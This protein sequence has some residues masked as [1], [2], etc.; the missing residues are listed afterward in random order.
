MIPLLSMQADLGRCDAEVWTAATSDALLAP[1][2]PLPL[3]LLGGLGPAAQP[4]APH[5]LLLGA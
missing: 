2:L 5:A 3:L 1:S 4:A